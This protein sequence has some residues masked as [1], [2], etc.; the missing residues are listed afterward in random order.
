MELLP[1]EKLL[2][3]SNNK[4]L[5]LTTHRVR[6]ETRASG[7]A[8]IKSIMLEELASCAVTRSSNPLLIVLAIVLLIAG[9]LVSL[10]INEPH[11]VIGGIVLGLLLLLL[12][13]ATREQ[14]LSLASAG[15][16][17]RVNTRGMKL[18]AVSDFVDAIEQAK[19]E[20]HLLTAPSSIKY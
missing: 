20:R 15:A 11:G 6:Q 4:T 19:N 10:N 2:L 8:Q 9:G 18:E 17:I 16:T 7:R 3:E 5:K 12:Y 1:Q 13:F 14:Y